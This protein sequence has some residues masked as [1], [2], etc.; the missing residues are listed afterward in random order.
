MMSPFKIHIP[1]P[2]EADAIH[3][4]ELVRRIREAWADERA[5][6][7]IELPVTVKV[8]ARNHIVTRMP[9]A[10][11]LV[12][13]RAIIERLIAEAQIRRLFPGPLPRRDDFTFETEALKGGSMATVLLIELA[14]KGA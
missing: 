13:V 5:D 14:P 7:R 1:I 2:G 3:H 8:T 6:I 12:T 11:R 10:D 9:I 4:D